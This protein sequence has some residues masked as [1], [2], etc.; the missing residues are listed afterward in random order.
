MA[1]KTLLIGLLHLN[2]KLVLILVMD[3]A[4]WMIKSSHLEY[5]LNSISVASH[6]L[7]SGLLAGALILS[8]L[9]DLLL[10]IRQLLR[11][12]MNGYISL[13]PGLKSSR[14]EKCSMCFDKIEC[15]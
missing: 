8:V 1:S 12:I 5:H 6:G 3:L 15:N 13:R 14:L 10:E 2:L 11:L 7:G 4:A 9:W